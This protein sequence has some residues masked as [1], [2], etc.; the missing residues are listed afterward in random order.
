M[1]E[2]FRRYSWRLHP[3]HCHNH[4]HGN[5]NNYNHRNGE[6][7]WTRWWDQYKWDFWTDGYRLH[8]NGTIHTAGAVAKSTDTTTGWSEQWHI[9]GRNWIDQR[10]HSN[11]TDLKPCSCCRRCCPTTAKWYWTL[12]YSLQKIM[13]LLFSKMH[14]SISFAMR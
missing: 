11:R 13:L 3:C 9:G 1:V 12:F 7:R 6:S 8:W 10:I 2:K 4:N 5:G 14:F